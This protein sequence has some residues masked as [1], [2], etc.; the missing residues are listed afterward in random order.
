MKGFGK[1]N[2]QQVRKSFLNL[3]CPDIVCLADTWVDLGS[4]VSNTIWSRY[5]FVFLDENIKNNGS[6]GVVIFGR[7]SVTPFTQTFIQIRDAMFENT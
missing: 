7:S 6:P 1:P 4:M 3:S 2:K 5:G